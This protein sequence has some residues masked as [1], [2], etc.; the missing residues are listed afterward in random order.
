[1]R[2]V[3]KS[4]GD[5]KGSILPVVLP[6]GR[7]KQQAQ[8]PGSP[9]PILEASALLLLPAFHKV[10]GQNPNQFR[11]EKKGREK[12]ETVR[13]QKMLGARVQE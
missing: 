8:G 4:I 10:A 11:P 5:S 3:W 13:R 1:M 9:S 2:E 12:S 7:G 6:C